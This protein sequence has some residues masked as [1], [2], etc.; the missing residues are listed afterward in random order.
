MARH[1]IP[2]P[3]TTGVVKVPVVM[4]LEVLEC[5]AASLTMIM[6]YYQKWI[7][8]EQARGDCGVSR[9]G[10]NAKNIILAARSYGME[11]K[12][13]RVDPEDLVAEGP[14]P[15]IIHWGFNHFVVLCG[16]RRGKAVLN[17]PA[18]GRVEVTMEEF[19]REYTGV[20]IT[21]E[22]GPDFVPSGKKKTVFS[23][24]KERLAGTSAAV[25]FV[26]LTTTISS[27][28]G[29]ISPV[30]SRVFLDRLLSG[31][32]P[33][34][35]MPFI[36]AMSAFTAVNIVV[37]WIAA[38]YSLRIQ[39]KMEAVGSTTY[40]WKVL[41]LP[42]QFFSQRM[43]AD[44]ADR[45]ATNAS[46]AGSLVNTFA[47]LALNTIMMLFY[48]V[49]MLKYSVPLTAVGIAAIGINL[50]VSLLITP[51]QVNLTRVQMRDNAKLSS[52]TAS[53]IRM[54]E[55]IKASGA[56]RGVFGRWAGFQASVN[57]QQ[58]KYIKMNTFLGVI[59][60]VVTSLTNIVVLG[61]GVYLVLHGAFTVGMVMAFQGFMSSFMQPA[62]SMISAGQSLQEMITQMERVD[63]VMS[64][65]TDPYLEERE[66][67]ADY[68]KLTG[69]IEM[70][71]IVFGYAP[72][73]DPL[74]T[75]FN[76][77]VK[78]GQKIALVGRSGCGKS[79]LA[80]LLSGLYQPWSGSIEFDGHPISEI[81]RNVF[82]GSV[83]VIDQSVTLFEDTVSANIKMWDNSIEDFEMI[84]AA[85]D[86]GI[87]EDIVIRPGGYQHK[88]SEN[89]R[90][91]SGG[92]RQRIEIAR[93]L[94][95]DPT[96]CILDE[97]TSALDA[98][99]E[100]EVVRSISM[101][102]ITCVIIAHRLSTIRDC[103]EIIVLDKG[104]VVE[105]G[106]HDELY[107][108]GGAYTALVTSE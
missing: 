30:F 108:K 29:V 35:L 1:I 48:L 45:Q 63:D 52:S 66:K 53:N 25:T 82:I 40:L 92:Q 102:G 105:R 32:N 50:A 16:F 62:N 69:A 83:A 26:V 18:R 43:A 73:G 88:M 89:G 46:I 79:T 96:I 61:A 68:E 76:L 44:I 94:S 33:E 71:D 106:T 77:S 8:L 22:P 58:N 38:V 72:L 13:W 97:A 6:H 39:G 21:V 86:A 85:R 31:R 24:A 101:R 90:D 51:K 20:M 70:K 11:A 37:L 56:E 75:N 87:H 4:Q 81:D 54:I 12:A 14:F 95:Q 91:F 78:P 80:K 60:T 41:R 103:D 34:W 84:M 3:Q 100:F 10:A 74:I 9:D 17:D 104:H 47:P 15:C 7:P 27:L 107:A 64:Y 55:T 23:Y 28:L 57:T 59:P 65:P 42:M 36:A 67:T 2:Q 5:G 49:A 93:A 19:D 98:K 99:T